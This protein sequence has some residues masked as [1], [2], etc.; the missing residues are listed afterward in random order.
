MLKRAGGS[1]HVA[2]NKLLLSPA[3]K[4]FLKIKE[5]CPVSSLGEK[6]VHGLSGVIFLVHI[7][8]LCLVTSPREFVTAVG[9]NLM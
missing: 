4:H 7:L 8:F 9:A 5:T 6:A 3:I 2:Q 1:L